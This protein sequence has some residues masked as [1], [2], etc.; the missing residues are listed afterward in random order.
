[1]ANAQKFSA[2]DKAFDENREK[3]WFDGMERAPER[4]GRESMGRKKKTRFGKK[5][6]SIDLTARKALNRKS[7]ERGQVFGF[8]KK[9]EKKQ[10]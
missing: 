6:R 2:Q 3:E 8:G 1:M 10:C 7:G 9:G 5:K 4:K